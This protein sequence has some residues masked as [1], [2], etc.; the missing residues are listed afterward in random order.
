MTDLAFVIVS[1]CRAHI[2]P[3]ECPKLFEYFLSSS[4]NI[5][6]VAVADSFAPQG[7]ILEL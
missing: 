6:S 4:L 1:I 7:K 5:P 3:S 2:S